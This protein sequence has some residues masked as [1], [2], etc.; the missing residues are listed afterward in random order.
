MGQPQP[1]TNCK[2]KTRPTTFFASS[3]ICAYGGLNPIK[4]SLDERFDRGNAFEHGADDPGDGGGVF[5]Q[6][7]RRFDF[8]FGGIPF[9]PRFEG[10]IPS[11]EVF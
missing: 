11:V 10:G 5:T 2:S 6:A 8:R 9:V 1:L 4:V 3:K 7:G